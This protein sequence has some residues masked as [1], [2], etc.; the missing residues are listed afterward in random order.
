MPSLSTKERKAKF[1]AN[2]LIFRKKFNL[3]SGTLLPAEYNSAESIT[4]KYRFFLTKSNQT[5]IFSNRPKN[6]FLKILSKK[7]MMIKKI[8][9]KIKGLKNVLN[10]VKNT[11]TIKRARNKWNKK[12]NKKKVK[13]VRWWNKRYIRKVRCRFNSFNK[14]MQF[15][16]KSY[17]YDS[18]EKERELRIL[19]KERINEIKAL[20]EKAENNDNELL[21]DLLNAKNPIP[22]LLTGLEYEKKDTLHNIAV[23]KSKLIKLEILPELI[24]LI[25]V[26][27]KV[28]RT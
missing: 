14:E 5:V 16:W 7:Y 12:W 25:Y 18:I 27:L 13:Y 28:T 2:D 11:R 21:D 10:E 9:D 8:N 4:N 22:K 19:A 24:I 20:K 17:E 3:P 15:F 6:L 26:I 1:N 23:L